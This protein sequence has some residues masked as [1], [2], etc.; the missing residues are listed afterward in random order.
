MVC[1][2]ANLDLCLSLEEKI[3]ISEHNGHLPFIHTFLTNY[4]LFLCQI[5]PNVV[6]IHDTNSFFAQNNPK[7]MFKNPM[8]IHTHVLPLGTNSQMTSWHQGSR[9]QLPANSLCSLITIFSLR[10]R[11]RSRFASLHTMNAACCVYKLNNVSL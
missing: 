11:H 4:Q 8:Y 9:S 6:N 10:E 5:F 2:E 7:V 3:V 1:N